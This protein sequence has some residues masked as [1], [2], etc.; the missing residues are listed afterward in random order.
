MRRRAE[1]APHSDPAERTAA[2]AAAQDQDGVI[3]LLPWV[4][5]PANGIEERSRRDRA[6]Y[7]MWVKQGKMIAL[8]GSSMDYT[9]VA[10]FMRDAL[11]D[12]DITP[13]SIEFDRW[14]IDVFKKAADDVQFAPWA[15][16]NNVGQG[17]RDFAPRVEAFE[18]LL[19]EGRI[20]HGNH[21]LLNMAAANA[22]AVSDP[23]GSRKIDKSKATQRID[24]LIAAIMATFAVS[25]GE[26]TQ[27]F[28]IDALIG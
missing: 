14:R 24:P 5:C 18:S 12:L 15:E 27:T 28:D 3:H 22:I 4:F 16:W 1:I 17:Y 20:R 10:E 23:S 7:N 11:D 2:V 9:H 21:P 6:P 13:T 25:E 26:T 19:L 8:G